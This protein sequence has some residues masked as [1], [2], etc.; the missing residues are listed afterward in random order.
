MPLA[1][2]TAPSQ[3]SYAANQGDA[4]E[5]VKNLNPSASVVVEA[6]PRT[7]SPQ[8]STLNVTNYDGS[9]YTIQTDAP[10]EFL[11]KLAVPFYTGWK[12]SVDDAPVAVYPADEALQGVFVPAGGHQ[13]KF[14][15]EQSGFRRSAALSIAGLL[16]CAVLCILPSPFS[17]LFR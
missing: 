14:W 17:N 13:V 9:S 16:L 15:F 7:I 2:V 8:G 3:I 10:A 6:T 5:A 11:L 12:A 4:H 1:R